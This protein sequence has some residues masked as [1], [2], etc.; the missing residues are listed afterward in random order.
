MSLPQQRFDG[1]RPFRKV[2]TTLPTIEGFEVIAIDTGRPVAHRETLKS[3]TGTAYRYNLAA[4]QGPKALA[5]VLRAGDHE[6]EGF[7]YKAWDERHSR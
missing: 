3:A 2:F 4:N 1:P 7:D 6:G 5:R